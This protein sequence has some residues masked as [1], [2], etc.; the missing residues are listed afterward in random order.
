M[1]RI[2]DLIDDEQFQEIEE[3]LSSG[4]DYEEGATTDFY[5]SQIP[6]EA[7]K[8]VKE[9]AKKKYGDDYGMAITHL[10]E[11]YRYNQ[12][13]LPRVQ[14]VEN[15]T[16]QLKQEIDN[17]KTQLSRESNNDSSEVSRLNE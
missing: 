3:K 9:L 4:I 11:H 6:V 16:E 2:S 12:Y 8:F 14:A 5:C 15:K 7:E 1:T 10:I 13:H 17:L